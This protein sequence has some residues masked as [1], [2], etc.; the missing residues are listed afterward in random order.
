M[1]PQNY[2]R[3]LEG[4]W[5][6]RKYK[7]QKFL[8]AGGY[9]AV[10]KADEVIVEIDKFIRQVAIKLIPLE[11][12]NLDQQIEELRI[13]SEFQ[14]PSL[15]NCYDSPFGKIYD[16]SGSVYDEENFLASVM[17][18]ADESLAD[19]FTQLMEKGVNK[20]PA[21]EVKIIIKS[22]AQG[23]DYLHN[24]DNCIVHRDLKPA[25]ILRVKKQWKIADFGVSSMVQKG[26]TAKTSKGRGTQDYMPP[27][28]YEGKVFSSWDMWSLGILTQ[29]LLTATHPFSAITEPELMRKVL[30]E[31][32]QIPDNLPVIFKEII[33]GCLVKEKDQRWTAKQV[34]EALIPLI[35]QKVPFTKWDL[36]GFLSLKGGNNNSFIEKLPDG[37]EL[38]MIGIPAGSFMMGSNDGYDTEKP[39][40]EVTL[41]KFYIGKYPITQ[42]QYEAVTGENPSYFKG[43]EKPVDSVN[44]FKAVK[45]CEKLSKLTGKKYKLPSEAQWEYACRGGR[46]GKWSFGDDKSKLKEYGWYGDNSGKSIINA[47]EIWLKRKNWDEYYQKIRANECQ[48]HRVGQKKGND[49]GIYDMQG[50]VW[51]WCEDHYVTS[52]EQTPRDGSAHILQQAESDTRRVLRCGSWYLYS[53]SCRSANRSINNPSF[54]L[55]LSGFRVVCL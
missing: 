18:I 43:K 42:A 33:K 23:L 16:E 12:N 1:Y 47:E 27:E 15:I 30:L 52:Y 19:Y 14:H 32:P 6:N 2:W 53:G 29:Q 4:N 36:G 22:L 45:Y 54:D 7:L 50:N 46:R 28:A 34:L 41:K 49:W 11:N 44:W 31:E 13:T 17:E 40:H 48:S 55:N 39:V 38:E 21:D 9:G 20:L 10:F 5:F 3:R 8:G 37:V 24:H 26:K 51:E 35:D 25:N